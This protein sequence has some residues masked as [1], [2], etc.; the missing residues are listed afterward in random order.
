MENRKLKKDNLNMFETIALSVAIIAPT[1][2]MALNISLM[3][4]TAGYSSPLIFLVATIVVGLV[5]YTVIKFNH[6]ISS[7]GSLY[8]FTK[9]ALGDKMGFTSGWALLLAYITLGAGT[10]A[11]FGAFFSQF[12][13]V[14]GINIPWLPLSLIFSVVMILVGSTDAK[15][16]TSLMLAMEGISI[17][18]IFI[19]SIV[20]IY[21]VGTTTG[22]SLKPFKTN[23]VKPS[24][25]ASTSVFAFLS[26]IGFE[27]AS[28]LGE[29]TKNPK[30]Y[31]P[32]AIGSAVFVTGL[33]YLLCSYAQVIG[34]GLD[35]E[36][37]KAVSTSAL[38]LTD[39]AD[40]YMSKSYGTLLLLSASLSFFSCALGSASAGARM[41]FSM[42][43][44]G[45]MPKSMSKVHHRFKTPCIALIFVVAISAIIQAALYMKGGIEVFGYYG[46]IG[47]LAILVSYIFTCVG[48]MVY[49]TKIKVWK[50][51]HLI[52]PTLS[53]VA[54]LY[55]LISNIY[56]IPEFPNNIFPYVVLGWIAI[57]LVLSNIFGKGKEVEEV[58]EEV[59]N[60]NLG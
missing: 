14:F 32:I 16:S 13:G 52:I 27:S 45:I 24:S 18:L 9:V 54:L 31:I 28:S 15:V 23:G 37:L 7:A 11:G 10:C 33:F 46:T 30:K 35:A 25:L 26:F 19:L 48:G 57:G 42:S 21:K 51:V 47:A 53:I 5:A 29:E 20:I 3:A 22:L 39:L 8:S 60:E 36:G 50:V 6:Y 55:V 43:K 1:A 58:E 59:V 44:D 2:A 38:P 17:F 41:L 34:F 56:P 40:K 12:L 4:Q 49:F